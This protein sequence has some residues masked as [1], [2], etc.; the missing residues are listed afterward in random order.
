MEVPLSS[1]LMICQEIL[2]ESEKA[3]LEESESE[4][5]VEDVT[6]EL[7]HQTFLIHERHGWTRRSGSRTRF[8]RQMQI[9]KQTNVKSSRTPTE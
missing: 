5:S 1:I 6:R 7:K 4:Q 8:T 3:T 2:L 9:I